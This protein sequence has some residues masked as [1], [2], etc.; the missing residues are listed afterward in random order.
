LTSFRLATFAAVVYDTSSDLYPV[1]YLLH[2]NGETQS[3]WMANVILNN[4][5]AAGRRFR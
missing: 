3:R 4:L 2:V 1:Y 5:I